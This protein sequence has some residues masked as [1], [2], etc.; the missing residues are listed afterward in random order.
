MNFAGMINQSLLDY[1]G[2]IATVLF[3]RGCNFSCPFCHNGHLLMNFGKAQNQVIEIAEVIEFLQERKSFLDAVVISGGEPTLHHD[4]PEAVR[5]FKE[6]GFLVKLDTNGT[7]VDMLGRLLEEKLLDYAAMDIKAPLDFKKYQEASGRLTNAEFFNVRAA[8]NLLQQAQIK[9]EF[10]TTV[11]PELHS[12]DDIEGIARYIKGAEVYSLQ[13]F[14]PS[15]TLDTL[16]QK[17]LPYSKEEMQELSLRC[18]PYVKEV[19]VVNI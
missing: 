9:V 17:C 4:L 6:M 8:V 15:N 13:Q 12:F 14:N 11:V 5:I 1:P 10:R 19:R 16:Y 18:A 7:N 2:E 3:T